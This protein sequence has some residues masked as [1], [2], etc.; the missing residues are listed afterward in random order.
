MPTRRILHRGRQLLGELLPELYTPLV[1]RVDP[2]YDTL[3][4]DAVLIE[5]DQLSERGRVQ[6]LKE[7]DSAR[8]AAGIDLVGYEGLHTRSRHA[9]THQSCPN[10]VGGLAGHERL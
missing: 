5:R 4:E 8:A 6:P 9:L 3:G 1:E 7:H 2:P 10:R